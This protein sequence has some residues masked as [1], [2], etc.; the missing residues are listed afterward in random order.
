MLITA[1]CN[2][3][4]CAGGQQCCCSALHTVLPLLAEFPSPQPSSV[5]SS[6]PYICNLRQRPALE[7]GSLGGW[8]RNHR[9]FPTRGDN[10]W[11]N[12]HVRCMQGILDY[13]E[14]LSCQL[15]IIRIARKFVQGLHRSGGHLC[16]YRIGRDDIMAER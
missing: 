5:H 8:Q 12:A 3:Q 1:E 15:D 11:H 6:W 16:Y 4:G 13:F 9:I 14:L 2:G 10:W 7:V